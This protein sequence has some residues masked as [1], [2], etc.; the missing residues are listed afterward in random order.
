MLCLYSEDLRLAFS[1][2]SNPIDCVLVMTFFFPKRVEVF[3]GSF[4]Q[5]FPNNNQ[6]YLST[7]PPSTAYTRY[8]RDQA[9]DVDNS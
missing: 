5:G 7:G 3:V 9:A 6:R 8:T 1:F 2:R 4:F